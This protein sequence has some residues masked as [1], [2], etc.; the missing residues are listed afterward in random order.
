MY[1]WFQCK[2]SP[3][4]YRL[5]WLLKCF[6]PI[7]ATP[8]RK[9]QYCAPSGRHSLCFL[10]A[11]SFSFTFCHS[12]LSLSR[13]VSPSLC[14]WITPSRLLCPSFFGC[15]SEVKSPL[16]YC[17]HHVSVFPLFP[18]FFFFFPCQSHFTPPLPHQL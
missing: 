9:R 3:P 2:Y 11:S 15:L 17:I 8:G 13:I 5:R 1:S 10:A 6:S 16:I 4:R 14:I 7:K 12:A 18:F